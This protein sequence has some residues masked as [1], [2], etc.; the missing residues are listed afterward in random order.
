[1]VCFSGRAYPGKRKDQK[2]S[3][4]EH[5]SVC[6]MRPSVLRSQAFLLPPL[7]SHVSDGILMIDSLISLKQKKNISDP[8]HTLLHI[9][10]CELKDCPLE[11][12]KNKKKKSLT[13]AHSADMYFCLQAIFSLVVA[14]T[15]LKV[16]K[17]K[18]CPGSGAKCFFKVGRFAVKSSIFSP[19]PE[20]THPLSEGERK[21][22]RVMV[23]EADISGAEIESCPKFVVEKPK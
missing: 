17:K 10:P 21:S 15:P 2:L 4:R 19:L 5:L 3:S 16:E 9:N 14:L 11:K 18:I 13:V 20:G 7:Q 12:K 23:R 1:M 8:H 22:A 6:D